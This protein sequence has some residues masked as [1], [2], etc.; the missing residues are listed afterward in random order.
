[1]NV[2]NMASCHQPTALHDYYHDYT[3][4]DT[5]LHLDLTVPSTVP[6]LIWSK[7][8]RT[9]HIQINWDGK[10]SGYAEN[11][12]NWIFLCKLATLAVCSLA[13][14]IYNMYLQLNLLTTP[15]LK[16]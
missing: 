11:Q 7:Y 14:T 8:S 6:Q 15:Y 13:V 10:P 5:Y 3:S 4:N 1:M 16:F 2:K 9:P 12:D